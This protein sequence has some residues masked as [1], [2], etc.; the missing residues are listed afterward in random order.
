VSDDPLE[1]GPGEPIA[2]IDPGRLRDVQVSE[3]AVRFGFGAA[4]SVVAG[5]I[6]LVVSPKAGGMFLAF[7]AIL[8]ATLTLLE[9]K[10]ATEHAVHTVRGAVVGSIGLVVFACVAAAAFTR[11]P[12]VV[13][14]AAAIAGWATVS[15]SV[16][17]AIAWSYRGSRR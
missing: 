16:Y 8:P 11:W 1:P 13:V 14:L 7:P 2:G 3:L 6:G 10:H 4:V 5:V 17:F 15:L 12:P 9:K